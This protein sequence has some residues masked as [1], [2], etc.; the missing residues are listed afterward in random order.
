VAEQL[1]LL[2]RA[3]DL[4]GVSMAYVKPHGALYH[5]VVADRAQ[6]GAGVDAVAGGGLPILG[7]PGSVLLEEAEDAGLA[8]GREFFADRAYEA[9]ATLVPR[10]RPDA[11]ITDLTVV[12]V[13]VAQVVESGTV[14]SAG[15]GVVAVEPDSI[16][17]HGDTPD[18]VEL[19]NAVTDVLQAHGIVIR[20]PW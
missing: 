1:E 14:T 16:C 9:D 19:A 7:L 10:D 3:A 13:R 11:V 18:A 17:V 12:A 8:V 15:G 5:R 20:A 6:A 4:E 2:C